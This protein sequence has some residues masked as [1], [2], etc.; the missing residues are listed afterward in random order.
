MKPIYAFCMFFL[1]VSAAV[2]AGIDS[3]Y[4]AKRLAQQDVDHALALTLQQCEPDRIDAVRDTAFLSIVMHE[5]G[6]QQR[7]QLTAN[8]GLTITRLWM[9]SDQ[10]ASGVLG[11]L[12]ALWL[13]VSL[14]WMRRKERIAD[15]LIQ[16]GCLQYDEEHHR[17]LVNGCCISFTPMQQELMKLFMTAPEH[18]L[19]QKDICDHLW[20]R[21]PDA[22]ATLYTLI[23]RLKRILHEVAGMN[24]EC[25]R[26]EA[27]QLKTS[28]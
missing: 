21:K 24:I 17:F 3:M 18:R 19:R 4:R 7:A 11:V 12:A 10:R 23:R 25:Q 16:L 27:Y 8:T 1:L 28:E 22:S 6:K 15:T 2:L 5:D 26:G 20:P 9:L 13:A 14:W